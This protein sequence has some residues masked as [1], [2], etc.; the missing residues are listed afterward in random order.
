MKPKLP[1]CGR[2]IAFALCVTILAASHWISP[3]WAEPARQQLSPQER[4]KLGERMYREGVLP[5]GEPMQA[6]VKGDL[7]VLGSAFSCV[8]CHLRAGIGSV[9]G[10]VYTPPTNSRNLYQP[11]KKYHKGVE[12]KY[13]E[14]PFHRPAY[15]DETLAAVLRGG[16]DPVGKVLNDVMPRYRLEDE[17]MGIMIS[18][19]KSLSSEFSPGITNTSIRF[20]TVVSEDISPEESAPMFDALA[21]YIS[22]KNNLRKN[23]QRTTTQRD[24]LMAKAMSVSRELEPRTL[25]LSRWVLKGPPETWRA[26]LE[27]YNRAEPAFALL[28]GMVK[29]DWKPIH[30]FCE[31]NKVPCLFPNTDFPVISDTDWYTLYISKGYFQEGEGVARFLNN[32]ETALKNDTIVQIVRS[33]PEGRA[34]AAGFAQTWQALD[35]APPIT[36]PLDAGQAITTAFP[37]RV[38]RSVCGR[39]H[40]LP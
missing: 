4:L 38:I 33:S 35:H 23:Y 29:G 10:G 22:D 3:A 14:D 9:E 13:G 17:E 39:L 32:E 5:S 36:V 40:G 15:T 37:V 31:D 26:Q 28:G 12:I 30:Q 34:L 2:L 18:Y 8:S 21:K 19:L 27:E 7:P 16:V 6:Y 1:P 24:R 20:A 25:S 11:L